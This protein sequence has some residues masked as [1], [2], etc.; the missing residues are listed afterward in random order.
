CVSERSLAPPTVQW[1]ER[2][3]AAELAA[4]IRDGAEDPRLRWDKE[5]RRVK[6]RTTKV[7]PVGTRATERQTKR[8][9][10]ELARAL[11]DA[12]ERDIGWWV[13]RERGRTGDAG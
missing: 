1:N 3:V 6:I 12:W 11:G 4:L 7:V 8:L 13:Q 2:T 10:E 9:H 5:R